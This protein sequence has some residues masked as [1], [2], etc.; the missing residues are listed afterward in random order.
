[1]RAMAEPLILY[2]TA[3]QSL[4]CFGLGLCAYLQ[5][6]LF[7]AA[8]YRIQPSGCLECTW[9]RA[10]SRTLKRKVNQSLEIL[11]KVGQD[12]ATA[13]G[14]HNLSSPVKLKRQKARFDET[15]LPFIF[16]SLI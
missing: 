8:R 11:L 9:T 13:Y 7:H 12:S 4:R 6:E 16:A 2:P 3:A 14:L 10:D 5:E 15:N 1:M